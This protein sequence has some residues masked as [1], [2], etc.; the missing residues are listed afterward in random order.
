MGRKEGVCCAPFVGKLRPRLIQ[1]GL[2]RG[3]LRYQVASSSIQPFGHNR[4][5]PK[6]GWDECAFFLG[7][8]SSPSNTKSPGP[9]PTAIPSGI[10][11]NPSV[12]PQRPLAENRGLCPFREGGAGSPSNTKSPGPRPTSNQEASWSMQTFGHNRY[13]SKIGGSARLL[14]RGSW[15]TT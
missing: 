12:W 8:A 5:G 13:V 3:L 9:R 4:H 7:R 10:L 14:G 2:D 15:V 6:L 1:C 11:V